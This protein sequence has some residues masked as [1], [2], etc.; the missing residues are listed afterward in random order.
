MHVRIFHDVYDANQMKTGWQSIL[1]LYDVFNL[2][3]M[4]TIWYNF[5][6]VLCI[7]DNIKVVARLD[8]IEWPYDTLH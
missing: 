4:F 2:I 8:Y 3:I 5:P 7:S 1:Q 6:C